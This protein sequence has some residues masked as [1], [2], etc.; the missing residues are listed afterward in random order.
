ML[1]PGAVGAAFTQR[2]LCTNKGPIPSATPQPL[3]ALVCV[4]SLITANQG[5]HTLQS[6]TT[7]IYTAICKLFQC[8]NTNEKKSYA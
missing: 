8:Q 6:V 4:F 1:V 7:S 3:K 2:T 5:K